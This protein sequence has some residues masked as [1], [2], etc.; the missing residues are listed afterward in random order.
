MPNSRPIRIGGG[1][2][3]DDWGYL[4]RLAE[5]GPVTQ[6]R[7]DLAGEHVV[8]IVGKRGSGKSYTLGSL[9]EGLV[10]NDLSSAIAS[11]NHSRGSLAI[12]H[13]GHLPMG[14]CPRDSLGRI[15][16]GPKSVPDSH[17]MGSSRD[18]DRRDGLEAAGGPPAHRAPAGN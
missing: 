8:A 2:N 11:T 4:G 3:N 15:L 5:A 6:V 13:A 1:D 14:G 18:R 12:R 10:L 9:I 17:R 16:R 7:H